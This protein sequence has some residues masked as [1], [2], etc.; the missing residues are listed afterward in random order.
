ME[1]LETLLG[2]L[3]VALDSARLYEETQRLAQRERL[4]RQITERVRAAPDMESI[5]QI[6]AEELIKALGGS[7]GFV[8]LSTRTLGRGEDGGDLRR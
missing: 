5:A 7:R 6:A 2:Q 8:K 4:A 1:L 3:E